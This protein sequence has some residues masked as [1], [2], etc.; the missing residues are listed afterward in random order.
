MDTIVSL[1]RS[2]A[3]GVMAL[4]MDLSRCR[5][6]VKIQQGFIDCPSALGHLQLRK[7]RNHTT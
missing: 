5:M 4:V 1:F 3:S 7:R 6:P 2:M